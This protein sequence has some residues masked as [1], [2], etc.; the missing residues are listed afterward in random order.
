MYGLL[1]IEVLFSECS[2]GV[3]G[4]LRPGLG[5]R[6]GGNESPAGATEK[7]GTCFGC[8]PTTLATSSFAPR[9][10]PGLDP[11]LGEGR[12]EFGPEVACDIC[13]LAVPSIDVGG[14]S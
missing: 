8:V 4:K 3:V 7:L 1:K 13:W 6:E 2:L 12:R 10:D 9:R 14:G 11:G 5:S